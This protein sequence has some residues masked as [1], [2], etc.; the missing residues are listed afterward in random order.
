V[1]LISR[2]MKALAV[3]DAVC[4]IFVGSCGK[5]EKPVAITAYHVLE[6]WVGLLIYIII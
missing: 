2:W 4:F 1:R 5:A 3:C 6:K